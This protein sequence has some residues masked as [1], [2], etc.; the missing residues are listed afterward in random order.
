L[1]VRIK[2]HSE[3]S[4][5]LPLIK[6]WGP[7]T[8]LYFY[9]VF[10]G[11]GLLN[12]ILI[13]PLY[14]TYKHGV[15][16]LSILQ[17]FSII[18]FIDSIILEAIADNQLKKFISKKENKGLVCKVGL[19]KY[20]RHPNYFFES[21]IWLSFSLFSLSYSPVAIVPYIIMLI[22]LRFVTGVPPAEASSLNS[23][24]EKFKIYQKE[25]NIFIPMPKNKIN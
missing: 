13:L 3:D 21:M 12:L 5:Y 2:K 20:S 1:F 22:L 19:W 18:V 16:D 25:T 23:K 8:P 10:I 6:R 7:K 4:R 24:P 11:Q 14:Y 9:L 17:I 15:N